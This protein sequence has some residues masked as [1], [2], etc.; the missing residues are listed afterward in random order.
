[1]HAKLWTGA[2]LIAS[3]VAHGAHAAESVEDRIAK[4]EEEIQHLKRDA[5]KEEAKPVAPSA[6]VAVK[7]DAPNV[8][9]GKKGLKF[10]SSDG[11]L[12]LRLHGYAQ[13]D[14]RTVS[15]DGSDSGSD[16]FIVRRA[17]PI[18]E[19]ELGSDFTFRLMYDF[20]EGQSRLFD[21]HVDYMPSK[22]VNVRVGKFKPP[23]GLER[24]KGAPDL[25][26]A[27]RG[28]TTNLAPNRDVGVMAYGAILPQLSYEAGAF[29]GVADL[30]N[31]D[32][33][34]DG[35][36]EFA[37]RL[38]AHPFIETDS[39]FKGLGVGVG[40][41]WG[42]KQ[43]SAAAREVGD[44]RTQSQARFFRYAGGAFAD[45]DH[46]RL[47]PQGYYYHGPLGALAEYAISN[48]EVRN[49]ANVDS[50]ENTAWETQVSYLVTGENASYRGWPVPKNTF[51][52]KNGGWGAWE[53]A[54]RYG[55]LK[56]DDD[57]FPL[58][59][60][61]AVSAKRAHSGGAAINGYLNENLKVTLD[62]ERTA[63]DGGS[64]AGGDRKT[65]DAL[66]SRLSVQF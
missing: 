49:G 35:G 47:A 61:P 42:E 37:G 10:T 65:E 16:E 41:S 51:N 15:G 66:I 64:T 26:F 25:T 28:M 24:L 54:A 57:A 19:G 4:L 63:F 52:P 11:D 56:I 18:V 44:Y 1:M 40:G 17:R 22:I 32:G 33:D 5:A 62:Y 8:E 12:S 2:F 21:A 3:G 34:D 27:E 43:G 7:S 38:F 58:F 6:P 55:E 13:L 53:V 60:D 14:N 48:Q 9:F 23:V 36:K 39:A 45:G 31:G 59:A 46:W 30:G 29:N 20:G 50:I